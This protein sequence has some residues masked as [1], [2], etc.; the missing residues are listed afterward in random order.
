MI[1]P[2]IIDTRDLGRRAG[3]MQE[4][5]RTFDAPTSIGTDYVQVKEGEPITIW[6]RL[7]CVIDGILASGQ[8]QTLAK[9]ECVRCLEPLEIDL[10]AEFQDMYSY[11]PMGEDTFQMDGDLLNLEPALRDA[12][13]LELPQSPLC[14]D[15]CLGLCPDCG[16]V[17][18]TDPSH[19]H[20]SIDPRWQALQG[21]LEDKEGFNDGSTKA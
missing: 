16:F 8:V 20:E 19:G 2:F 6:L 5:T 12:L 18:K 15:D 7:E 14:S 9:T 1:S 10:Q 11:E 13:V 3:A 21:L 17:M 4:L